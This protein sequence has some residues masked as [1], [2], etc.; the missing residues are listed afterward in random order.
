MRALPAVTGRDE[1]DALVVRTDYLDDQAWRGV[2]AELMKPWGDMPYEA[3]VHFVD[4]PVWAE[5][6]PDEVLTAVRDDDN[7]VAVFLADRTTM[8]AESHPL[9]A[10]TTLTR[11]ECFDDEDYERLTEFGRDFRVAPAQLNEVHAN[12]SIG[13]L[14]FEE[15]AGW[16]YDDPEGIFRSA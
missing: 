13:N 14:G 3:D 1:F 4:D 6:T 15:F 8:Q 7:L 5:A 10:V 11:E 2:A 9:L 12:L 16:A